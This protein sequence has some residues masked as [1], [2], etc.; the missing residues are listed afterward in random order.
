M[1]TLGEDVQRVLL[2]EEFSG[3]FGLVSL[4]E[5]T[6]NYDGPRVMDRNWHNSQATLEGLSP[7]GEM[8][9]AGTANSADSRL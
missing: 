2:I 4:S 6:P 3:G 9:F 8:R 1:E 5:E 7:A